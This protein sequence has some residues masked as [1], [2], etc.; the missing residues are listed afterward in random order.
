V[1]LRTQT[2]ESI[3]TTTEIIGTTSPAEPSTGTT[4]KENIV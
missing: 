3:T 1:Q 4:G 2:S